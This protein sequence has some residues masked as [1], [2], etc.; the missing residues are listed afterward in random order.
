AIERTKSEQP[1]AAGAL[2]QPRAASLK[3][4]A[5]P[6]GSM[7]VGNTIK[8]DRLA[9]P[10][11][12]ISPMPHPASVGTTP[13]GISSNNGAAKLK[14]VGVHGVNSIGASNLIAPSPN[15]PAKLP[16]QPVTGPNGKMALPTNRP[17]PP[18][19][20]P[21]EEKKHGQGNTSDR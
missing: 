1:L 11:T 9:K 15:V 6:P 18:P 20:K 14:D 3:L 21:N 10:I 12:P 19:H 2:S 8:S 17:K 13:T 7:S 16:G 4:P 5:P